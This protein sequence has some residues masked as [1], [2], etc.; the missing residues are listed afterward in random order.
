MASNVSLCKRCL[1]DRN[2]VPEIPACYLLVA[3]PKSS[4]T[5]IAARSVGMLRNR[6]C[7]KPER[8]ASGA[9]I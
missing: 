6:A 7:Y 5:G 4:P 2:C 9:S 8:T 3:P 1:P